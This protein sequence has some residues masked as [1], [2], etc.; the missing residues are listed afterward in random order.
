M[1]IETDRLLMRPPTRADLP[2]LV[3]LRSD[4]D[5]SRYLGGAA[6]AKPEVLD[7][8]LDFYIGCHERH[9][10]AMG[11]LLRKDGGGMIGW[12]GLQP[13]EETGEIE[14]GYSFAK[15]HW[16]QGYATET[17]AAWLR[18]GFARAGLARIVAV[19]SPENTA[20]RRVMEKLGMRYE[21]NAPHYGLDC[22]FYAVS[23]AEFTPRA[24]VYALHEGPI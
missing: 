22:V 12:G 17:A 10:F 5:V 3:E 11:P 15:A 16:G 23:R 14:V 4:E 24:G 21:K 19:A 8:R 1:I 6:M 18:Y 13:L 9:G 20:S 2:A 7:Q